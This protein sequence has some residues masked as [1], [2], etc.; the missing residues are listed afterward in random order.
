MPFSVV[1]PEQVDPGFRNR[2]N[3]YA[4][5]AALRLGIAVPEIEYWR[6]DPKGNITWY[7]DR[8]IAHACGRNI[9]LV[10]DIPERSLAWV[11]RHEM[12]HVYQHMEG[13]LVFQKDQKEI[14][15]DNFA[16]EMEQN[17]N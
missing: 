17:E 3:F 7:P 11:V 14:D 9:V 12:R 13:L 2:V 16:R 5:E 10:L 4:A 15:A 1:A 8:W 6:F